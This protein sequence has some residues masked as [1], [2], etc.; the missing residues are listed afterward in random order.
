MRK[1]FKQW[2]QISFLI[3]IFPILSLLFFFALKFVLKFFQ[4]FINK[5]R[6]N[7]LE[8]RDEKCQKLWFQIYHHHVQSPERDTTKVH[9]AD[10]L[11]SLVNSGGDISALSLH[12]FCSWCKAGSCQGVWRDKDLLNINNMTKMRRKHC[13]G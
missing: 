13:Q 1:K 12:S 6:R 11:T 7:V 9:K 10:A 2:Q 8:T 3:M 5:Y 4:I